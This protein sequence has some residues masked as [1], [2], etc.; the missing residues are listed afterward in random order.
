MEYAGVQQ[1]LI[2]V[3]PLKTLVLEDGHFCKPQRKSLSSSLHWTCLGPLCKPDHWH[4]CF[5]LKHVSSFRMISPEQLT[6]N[7]TTPTGLP[8]LST[9]GRI[10]SRRNYSSLMRFHAT[11]RLPAAYHLALSLALSLGCCC[12]GVPGVEGQN[13]AGPRRPREED[14]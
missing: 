14:E 6:R 9:T 3:L 10:T 5:R 7:R 8:I 4:A 1:S 2:I 13:V 11:G 12:P